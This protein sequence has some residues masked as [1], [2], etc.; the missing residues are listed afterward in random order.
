MPGRKTIHV[1]PCVYFQLPKC[2]Q[3]GKG[4]CLLYSRVEDKG[5]P[6]KAFH[7]KKILI[8]N[9]ASPCTDCLSDL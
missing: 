7:L 9:V 4:V 6:G 2:H 8:I 1:Y 5:K 3:I